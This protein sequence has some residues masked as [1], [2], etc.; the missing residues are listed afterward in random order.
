MVEEVRGKRARE[1]RSRAL[2]IVAIGCLAACL[3]SPPS[4]DDGD[5]DGDGDGPI[6]LLENP[7]FEEG[8]AGWN[9]DGSVEVS[10][11]EELSLP[12]SEAGLQVAVLG[13]ADFDIDSLDQ[14]VT[15]PPWA[16][17]LELSGTRCFSS[18]EGAEQAYDEFWIYLESLDGLDVEDL[19]EASNQDATG[20]TCVWTS[21]RQATAAH[22]GEELRFVVEAVMD[23][24]VSSS[25]AIDDLALTA[26]P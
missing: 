7:S 2:A 8:V 6:Q 19:V 18:D 11:T 17:Q 3:E 16:Q 22:A 24:E 14:V 26:S 12:P 13:R 15:V 9:A 21:F 1:T 10:T 4:G 5:G 23:E 20:N 25:F